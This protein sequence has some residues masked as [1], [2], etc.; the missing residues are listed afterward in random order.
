LV[1][2]SEYL[3]CGRVEDRKTGACDFTVTSFKSH[4]EN[5]V[6]FFEKY[7]LQGSKYL[8]YLAFRKV[9]D[10]M[11][12]KGHLSREGLDEITR[13]KSEMNKR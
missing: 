9:M 11:K 7:P 1:G 13:I 12:V 4:N 8:N 3:S 5:L 2:I 10:I 6:P